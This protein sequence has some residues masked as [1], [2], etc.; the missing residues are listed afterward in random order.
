[1]RRNV[2]RLA[3]RMGFVPYIGATQN[4]DL[5][6]YGLTTT[7]LGV[8]GNLDVDTLNLNANVISDSTGT[9]SFDDDNL[10]TTGTGQFDGGLEDN[11]GNVVVDLVNQFLYDSWGNLAVDWDAYYLND[12]GGN[13]ALDWES[14]YLVANDG[15]DVILNWTTVGLA[16]FQD[17]AVVTTSTGQFDGGLEDNAANV[18]VDLV[19][20][21]L[22]DI[23]GN[24]SID[25]E[26]RRLYANDGIDV[27]LDWD[28]PGTAGF[29]DT[30]LTTTGTGT[31]GT[32]T[33][34]GGLITDTTGAISFGNEDLTTTGDL[35]AMHGNFSHGV[36][37]S[38]SSDDPWGIQLNVQY[39]W[40]DLSVGNNRYPVNVDQ[41]AY[42]LGTRQLNGLT[43]D[44][45]PDAAAGIQAGTVAGIYGQ[46][47]LE[48]AGTATM[49][50]EALGARCWVFLNGVGTVDYATA[51]K[52]QV[53]IANAL[54]G[55]IGVARSFHAATMDAEDGTIS[56]GYHFY[57]SSPAVDGGAFTLFAHMWLEDAVAAGTN[58][59][60]V[61]DS[62][63]IGLTLGAAQDV[64]IYWD[65][66]A[67]NLGASNIVTTGRIATGTTTV[68]AAGP[69]D[70]LDVSGVNVVFL[71]CSANN[72][73]IGGFVGG[74][75]GQVIHIARLCA[76]AFS[77]TLEHNEGTGNQDIFLHA[78]ADESL[79]TEY[80]GWTLACN[81]TH[82]YDVS[83]AR[84]V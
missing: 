43:F 66:A 27:I 38:P 33:L 58:Y 75:N 48:L 71:D 11:A 10:V 63:T 60:I 45:N 74:V 34:A 77:A 18:V 17:S 1:M 4:V 51:M 62:D 6:A 8:F 37:I 69:T 72:V 67:T 82:W 56:A 41:R 25:W 14:R 30:N 32:L 79:L 24:T 49:T 9:I 65:G 50:A 19:A 40:W 7:G 29:G 57:G 26:N 84:H 44:V 21:N 47:D 68:S 31:Y 73:T 59:G 12:S 64:T 46:V 42:V 70:N 16:D 52:G 54:A 22:Q 78:G 20:L 61:I 35:N 13:V 2:G 28:T 53:D 5:G 39:A 81:G 76:A 23:A 15:A 55:T 36:D 80:G 3:A 83:H